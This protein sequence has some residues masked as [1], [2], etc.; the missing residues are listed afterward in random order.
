MLEGRVKTLQPEVF[1]GIL[2]RKSSPD[3]MR[4]ISEKGIG[5]IDMVVCNFY[6]FEA[7]AAKKKLEG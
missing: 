5:T 3:H 2:A 7:T 4:Q 1:A 6:A